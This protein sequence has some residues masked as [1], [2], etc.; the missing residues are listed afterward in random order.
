MYEVDFLG[1]QQTTG[2]KWDQ[3]LCA[4][5]DARRE[6]RRTS[7]SSG[8]SAKISESSTSGPS[9]SSPK[10][11]SW[12]ETGFEGAGAGIDTLA[13]L[14]GHVI[15]AVFLDREGSQGGT[16]VSLTFSGL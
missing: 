5:V 6:E 14:I 13:A 10:S 16:Q 12:S 4:L 2:M 9:S 7:V 3:R 15:S 1:T 11:S 8:R